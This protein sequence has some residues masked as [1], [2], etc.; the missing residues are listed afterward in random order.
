MTASDIT[1]LLQR[2]APSFLPGAG[3]TGNVTVEVTGSVKRPNA[4][5]WFAELATDRGVSRVV[6]KCGMAGSIGPFQHLPRLTPTPALPAMMGRQNA[7]LKAIEAAVASAADPRFEA[8]HSLTHDEAAR[9]LVMTR[10]PG[11]ELLQHLLRLKGSTD[12][13]VHQALLRCTRDAGGWLRMFHDRVQMEPG[14]H[15]FGSMRSLCD[16][17]ALWQ[18]DVGR[19][20]GRWGGTLN[21]RMVETAEDLEHPHSALLHGDFW[22]GNIIVGNGRLAVIDPIAW[23]HGPVWLDLAYFILLL[24]TTDEQVRA[25]GLGWPAEVLTEAEREFLKGYFA[26][27]PFDHRALWLFKVFALLA[28]WA[29]SAQVR[30]QTPGLRRLGKHGSFAWKSRYYR[31]LLRQFESNLAGAG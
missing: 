25:Q 29:R 14:R 20:L 11:E 27:V 4:R 19:G 2:Q 6:V 21:R 16:Q 24:R 26:D 13:E 15:V 12:R 22:P 23:A 5:I 30:D 18:D 7:A 31:A 3:E 9:V 28:K 1:D 17:A 10:A 8:V